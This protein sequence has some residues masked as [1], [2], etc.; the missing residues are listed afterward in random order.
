M[1]IALYNNFFYNFHPIHCQ[2]IQF[3]CIMQVIQISIQ[4]WTRFYLRIYLDFIYRRLHIFYTRI[5]G[6]SASKVQISE[7]RL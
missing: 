6:F 4:V 7:R 2:D 1:L 5:N 3:S